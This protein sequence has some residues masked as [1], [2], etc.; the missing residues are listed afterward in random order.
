MTS[1]IQIY[2]LLPRYFLKCFRDDA[3]VTH[4]ILTDCLRFGFFGFI[5]Y[6]TTE[7]LACCLFF[8]SF[9]TQVM[10]PELTVF[11]LS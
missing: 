8:F 7:L 11:V 6:W 5:Y 2:S 10:F 9:V 1:T 3:F 4:S